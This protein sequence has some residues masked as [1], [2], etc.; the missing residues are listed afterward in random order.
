MNENDFE[1]LIAAH[2]FVSSRLIFFFNNEEFADA[3]FVIN[4]F[5]VFGI[6]LVTIAFIQDNENVE[7][8]AQLL[9]QFHKTIVKRIVNRI[10]DDLHDDVSEEQEDALYEKILAIFQERLRLYFN[11]FHQKKDHEAFAAI[12]EVFIDHAIQDNKDALVCDRF[13]GFSNELFLETVNLLKKS[14]EMQKNVTTS[15]SR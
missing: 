6:F 10:I 8:S 4:E 7:E 13:S 12:A 14:F 15:P 3:S 5:E 1:P 2:D 11:M 9:E